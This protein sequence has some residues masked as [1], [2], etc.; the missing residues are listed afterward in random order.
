MYVCSDMQMIL[1][2]TSWLLIQHS[3]SPIKVGSVHTSPT[4]CDLFVTFPKA[5]IS[6]K[7]VSIELYLYNEQVPRQTPIKISL[8][9]L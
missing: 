1:R 3:G 8:L 6:H 9:Y 2:T 7:L 4:S 5:V